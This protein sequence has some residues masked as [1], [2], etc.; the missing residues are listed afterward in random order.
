METLRK[1]EDELTKIYQYSG[2]GFFGSYLLGVTG[3]YFMRGRSTPL[4]AALVKHTI[5]SVTGTFVASLTAE[6]LASELYYNKLLI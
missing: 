4:F 1:R 5:L 6:R 2:W 3:Y